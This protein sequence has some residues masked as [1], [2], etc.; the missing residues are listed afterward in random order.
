MISKV[1]L[2][3]TCKDTSFYSFIRR[4]TLEQ[5]KALNTGLALMHS[6]SILENVSG[7]EEVKIEKEIKRVL[8]KIDKLR[9]RIDTNSDKINLE[10]KRIDTNLIKLNKLKENRLKLKDDFRDNYFESDSLQHVLKTMHIIQEDTADL[11]IEKINKDYSLNKILTG[12][13]SLRTYCK[14]TPLMINSKKFVFENIDS[15]FYIKN[16][17]GYDV[18]IKNGI[19]FIN[20]DSKFISNKF[21][22]SKIDS[23]FSHNL[24]D[25]YTLNFIVNN[26][27]NKKYNIFNSSIGFTNDNLLIIEF[28]IDTPEIN[29]RYIPIKGR[30]LGIDLGMRNIA[31]ICLNDNIRIHKKIGTS[32]KFIKSRNIVNFQKLKNSD[33]A[34]TVK[35]CKKVEL[36]KYSN[37]IINN[38]IDFAKYN[39]CEYINLEKLHVNEFGKNLFDGWTYANFQQS[40]EREA[41]KEGIIVRYINRSFTSQKCSKCGY[42][43]KNNHVLSS[44]KCNKCGLKLDSDYNAA[45]NIAR[46]ND[47]V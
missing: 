34:E 28:L 33:K 31:Y 38:I 14:N 30:T 42:I 11:V 18:K 16:L 29:H 46:S 8:S 13:R 7:G 15:S 32:D 44:F 43:D 25:T 5:N 6:Y 17:F 21:I 36:D 47:F 9:K 12:E 26:I 10:E 4:E 27:I 41:A 39:F 3:L 23:N 20:K 22:L 35:S 19:K 45:I 24:S 37:R 2:N 1:Q 40:I